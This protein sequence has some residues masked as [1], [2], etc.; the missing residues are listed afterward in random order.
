MR[1][2]VP[3]ERLTATMIM[4]SVRGAP[5][6][7][8]VSLPRSRMLVVSDGISKVATAVGTAVGGVGIPSKNGGA[9][10]N[11][12]EGD[13]WGALVGVC[14]GATVMVGMGGVSV[15]VGVGPGVFVPAGVSL[16]VIVAVGMISS[17]AVGEGVDVSFS[18]AVEE[19]LRPATTALVGVGGFVPHPVSRSVVM[20]MARM[21]MIGYFLFEVTIILT[22]LD[23]VC[24]RCLIF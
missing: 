17:V 4:V 5:S 3:V 19:R 15:A 8:G 9:A 7:R 14:V 1:E 24:V 11:S 13:S 2:A 6:L 18:S 23:K 12:S 22:L 10:V 20:M 21:R 16:G